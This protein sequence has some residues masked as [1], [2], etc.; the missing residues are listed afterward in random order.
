MR[1]V[2]EAVTY[3][4]LN[5]YYNRRSGSHQHPPLLYLLSFSTFGSLLSALG[6]LCLSQHL[7]SPPPRGV[8]L[9]L[10]LSAVILFELQ[11]SPLHPLS[12]QVPEYYCKEKT[13]FNSRKN[14]FRKRVNFQYAGKL[15]LI[16]SSRCSPRI[17]PLSLLPPL[18]SHSKPILNPSNIMGSSPHTSMFLASLFYS[19]FHIFP[20]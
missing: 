20:T 8:N 1:H 18:H 14:L 7:V 5:V 6:L 11:L 3:L 15:L 4:K 19:R 17:A 16:L 12:K 13:N 10:Q 2:P 9:K